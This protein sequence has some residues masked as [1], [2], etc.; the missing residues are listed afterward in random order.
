M[1]RNKQHSNKEVDLEE[2]GEEIGGLKIMKLYC[3]K[4]SK[5]YQNYNI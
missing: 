1:K 4:F 3:M 5:N 2:L